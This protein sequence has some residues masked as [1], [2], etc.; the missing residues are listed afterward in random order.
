MDAL[1]PAGRRLAKI[2]GVDPVNYFGIAHSLLFDH[3]FDLT[4]EFARIPPDA[5]EWTQVQ[6]SGLPG[7]PWGTG[8]S[9]LE[10]PFLAAGT[11]LDHIAGNQADGYG[12]FA[13]LLYCFGS[14][15]FVGLGLFA[16]YGALRNS[17]DLLG[18]EEVTP[19]L[20]LFI[21]GA[22]FLGTNVGYYSF[23][24]ISHAST[25]LMA[26]TF[27][28]CW[29]TARR[30]DNVKWWLFTGLAGGFLSVCRWQDIL[31][32]GGILFYELANGN[33]LKKSASWWKSRMAL[34]GGVILC[35]IP[36]IAEWKIIYGKYI[37]IPQ[38]PGFL[39]FPPVSIPLVLLSSRNGWFTWTPLALLGCAGLLIG[40]L[41]LPRR[42]GPWMLVLLLAVS[43]IGSMPLWHGVDSFSSR[44]LVSMVPIAS[45][46]LC[47]LVANSG[48]WTRSALV[49]TIVLCCAYSALFAIQFRFDL[50]PTNERLTV[51][52]MV[53]DK[54]RLPSVRQ[55]KAALAAGRQAIARGDLAGAITALEPARRWGEDRQI[56]RELAR[57]YRAMGN[58]GAASAA[59]ATY[60]RLQQSRLP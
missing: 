45:L 11:V 57:A 36:Q 46:G 38:G 37:T 16:L 41:K 50:V 27:L 5:R 54:F 26:S 8:Y 42:L 51:G 40:V 30:G 39:K 3:D 9:T 20:A 29:L 7:S 49:T 13:I 44:Y 25:F 47:R 1:A 35:W 2:R 55:R 52:E 53:W 12:P 31:Y 28:A 43:V 14:P 4:N 15:V 59:D 24:Q 10:I 60:E 19:G 6:P 17:A 23:S 32:L 56:E 58:S 33:I 48:G 21:V 22:V 18:L 34:V